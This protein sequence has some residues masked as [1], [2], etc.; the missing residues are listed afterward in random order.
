MNEIKKLDEKLQPKID[1]GEASN[2]IKAQE[3]TKDDYFRGVA[4]KYE[5]T[6]PIKDSI[7]RLDQEA[8]IVET[9]RADKPVLI[10]GNWRMGKTS[11]M[12]SLQTHQFGLKNSIVADVMM[13]N[14]YSAKSLKNFQKQ[15]GLNA[16]VEFI[17][18]REF[19]KKDELRKQI[20]KSRKFPF[21]FLNDYLIEHGEKVFLS[22]DEVIFFA[23][24]LEKLKYLANLKSLSNIQITLVLHRVA[25]YESSF[26]EI[27]EE[28][29]T[30]FVR[31]L[32]LEEV[33]TLVRK[34]LEGTRITFTDDAIQRIFEFTGGRPMEI[35]NVCW[36]LM[37]SSEHKNYKFTYSAED[38]DALTRKETWELGEPFRIAIVNYK[39]IYTSSMNNEEQAIIDKLIEKGEVPVSEIEAVKVQPLI[40]TTFV[41]RDFAKGAYRINGELFKRVVLDKNLWPRITY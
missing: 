26:K 17:A 6:R 19:K 38:I 28:Y 1:A 13:E 9:L 10:R 8:K 14:P 40:D 20:T 23:E 30:H 37:G 33:E 12:E 29:E 11:M 2:F 4:R 18:K 25:Y 27:F 3:L 15:F 21:E 5:Q 31:A 39:N 32:T 41:T 24:E 22:L 7:V 34:P 35:N 16:V 36:A